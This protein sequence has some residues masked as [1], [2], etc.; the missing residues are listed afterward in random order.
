MVMVA[1]N[2]QVRRSSGGCLRREDGRSEAAKTIAV[3]QTEGSRRSG[4]SDGCKV[5]REDES[6]NS[7]VTVSVDD[8]S[9]AVSDGEKHQNAS[10]NNV[11]DT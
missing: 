6:D 11:L 4:R 1:G 9:R 2:I 10:V 5:R 8:R 3:E 7:L